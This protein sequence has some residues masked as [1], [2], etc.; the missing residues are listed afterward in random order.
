MNITSDKHLNVLDKNTNTVMLDNVKKI[1]PEFLAHYIVATIGIYALSSSCQE[2]TTSYDKYCKTPWDDA[3]C[4]GRNLSKE[5]T[6]SVKNTAD[7]VGGSFALA[8]GITLAVFSI[9][10]AKSAIRHIRAPVSEK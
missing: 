9:S 10:L 3:G 4:F 8:F 1:L 2:S 6:C 5:I 7:K